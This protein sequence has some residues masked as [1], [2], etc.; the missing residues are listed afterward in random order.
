MECRCDFGIGSQTLYNPQSRQSTK[1]S[2]QSSNLGSPTPSHAGECVTPPPFGSGGGGHTRLR[3]RGWGSPN[4]NEDRHCMWYSRYIC[5]VCTL[6][7]NHSARPHPQ[8]I[9]KSTQWD[10][11]RLQGNTSKIYMHGIFTPTFSQQSVSQPWKT[12]PIGQCR[13]KPHPPVSELS[14]WV[15]CGVST[16]PPTSERL[17]AD[18]VLCWYA[19]NYILWHAGQLAP[20]G[21][22]Q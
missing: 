17:L 4:S 21:C 2:F 3:E 22:L 11:A 1:L 16:P 15:G 5:T 19:S 8:T 12:T 9:V 10:I 18:M 20:N 7:S 6:C 14:G 13:G